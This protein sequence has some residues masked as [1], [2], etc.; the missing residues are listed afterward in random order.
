MYDFQ[1]FKKNYF[2]WFKIKSPRPD[3][4]FNALN[5]IKNALVIF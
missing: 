1:N 2:F 3:E 5:K 4:N